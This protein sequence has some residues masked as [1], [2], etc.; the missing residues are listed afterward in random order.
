MRNVSQIRDFVQDF[1]N[2]F[3]KPS[4]E[5][6]L[7]LL[8]GWILC[9]CRRFV[10]SIFSYGVNFRLDEDFL[11]YAEMENGEAWFSGAPQRRL[12]F[13]AWLPTGRFFGLHVAGM[14]FLLIFVVL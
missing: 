7:N 1:H 13:V 3:T 2:V 11:D 8:E 5:L 12:F 6:F 14:R 9:P 4:C 10:T